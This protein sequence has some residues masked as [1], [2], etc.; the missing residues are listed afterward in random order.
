MGSASILFA[1]MFLFYAFC[2]FT[3]S[4]FGR[5]EDLE[6]SLQ[7]K[8]RIWQGFGFVGLALVSIGVF[9][10]EFI[11]RIRLELG[12]ALIWFGIPY[13]IPL[14]Y[15]FWVNYHLKVWPWQQR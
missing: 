8:W 4:K 2:A 7:K 14:L 13:A 9:I 6:E 10:V 15:I 5:R 3:N 11:Y 1:L 12:E